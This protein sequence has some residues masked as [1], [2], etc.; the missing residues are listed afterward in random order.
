MSYLDP[1]RLHFAGSFRAD[2]ST[3]NNVA[4]HFDNEH[5]KKEDQLPGPN[6][7]NG[8]WQPQGTGAW[9][10]VGCTVTGA[11]GTDALAAGPKAD[12][13][14]GLR[15]LDTG[16][17]VSA[18]LVDLDP[19]Q[20]LVSTIFGL[21]LR[22]VDSNRATILMKGRFK[23]APFYDIWWTRAV[24][25]SGD[26]GASAFFQSVLTDV[27]W[28]DSDASPLLT[29]LRAAST[30]GFL[31]I[32]FMTDDY[33]MG[34]PRRGYGRIVGTIGPHRAGEPSHCVLGR[35][36]APVPSSGAL[37]RVVCRLD[38]GSKQIL[39]DFGNAIHTSG[40]RL[41]DAGD[42]R[43]AVLGRDGVHDLGNL[44]GYAKPGWYEAT[45]GIQSFPIRK[46]VDLATWAIA[47]SAPLAVVAPA[48]NSPGKFTI[49]AREASNGLYTRPDDL[50]VRLEPGAG[51][52]VPIVVTRFGKP[53]AG[54][55]ITVKVTDRGLQSDGEGVAL[56]VPADALKAASG[57]PTDAAG[58]T[59]VHVTGA[60][61]G[62]PRGM[63]LDGQ[64]FAVELRVDGAQSSGTDFDP[65][66]FISVLL[67][68]RT[69]VPAHV[70]WQRDVLPILQ[71]YSNLYPRPHGPDRYAPFKDQP[72]LHPVVN[73]ADPAAVARYARHIRSAL[74]LPF[75][76]PNHMPVVR[77]LSQ[78]R[79]AILLK[80][81]DQM[82]A[83]EA[84][85]AAPHP[86]AA[87][88][89]VA[90]AQAPLRDGEI[91]L[92]PLGGKTEALRR[93][94]RRGSSA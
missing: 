15:L 91:E 79:R 25:G 7:T 10:L 30:P 51:Q 59:V 57:A 83:G 32:K 82:L 65:N 48:L 29:A 54:A 56:A 63:F 47:E 4:A 58:R 12:P 62:H 31:S 71:Q 78:T 46:T 68:G 66:C 77:D 85:P 67:F 13:V 40:D 17:R 14:V 64:V 80:W 16:D 1:V 37:D 53:Q 93:M 50:V 27:V 84:V 75:D 23:P 87:D 94:V 60:D 2:V 36:L 81:M 92:A 42:L 24:G 76:H 8:L 5:F 52:D 34:G 38:A 28:T 21:E 69:D 44:S 26:V 41:Q 3:V 35:H 33:A 90:E 86:V 11:A 70:E 61:P 19:N 72:P 22:I 49:L 73:L 89:V 39:A 20:Q 43:L 55:K 6:S 45:A 9:R 88:L 18:K 74:S